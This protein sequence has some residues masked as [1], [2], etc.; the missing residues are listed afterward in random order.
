MFSRIDKKGKLR[1]TL[2]R[3]SLVGTHPSESDAEAALRSLLRPVSSDAESPGDAGG[4]STGGKAKIS[5]PLA[6]N[7]A[8][9]WRIASE[10]VGSRPSLESGD[11]SAADDIFAERASIGRTDNPVAATH[12]V[13][14]K[15]P[16]HPPATGEDSVFR[17]SWSPRKS[18]SGSTP[19]NSQMGSHRDAAL[20]SSGIAIKSKVVGGGQ[21]FDPSGVQ[22][23]PLN[24]S[25]E[26]AMG[27]G[28]ISNPWGLP[29]AVQSTPEAGDTFSP[30]GA[31]AEHAAPGGD[32][33]FS[34]PISSAPVSRDAEQSGRRFGTEPTMVAEPGDSDGGMLATAGAAYNGPECAETDLEG[35]GADPESNSA[36]AGQGSSG[37][38]ADA[39]HK[40]NG[41]DDTDHAPA[42][43]LQQEPKQEPEPEANEG[44]EPADAE[45]PAAE[46]PA[47]QKWLSAPVGA[48]LHT[49][50]VTFA[51][52][53]SPT[54]DEIESVVACVGVVQRVA[55]GLGGFWGGCWVDLFG[56]QA[57]GL[58][59]PG[60]DIDM[61]VQGV[62]E[63]MA[64]PQSQQE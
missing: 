51:R 57:M 26:L 27:V 19:R 35:S 59:V 42:S 17:I 36:D 25:S 6:S 14:A 16:S 44:G 18:A 5:A 9:G 58:G 55:R 53:L 4:S 15:P 7:P 2:W 8:E 10:D 29:S 56:S 28:G 50:I 33:Y 23:G 40:R 60:S 52:A 21:L 1:E 11:G 39:V 45:L 49:D 24:G 61:V 32:W 34:A 43:A 47:R 54:A 22:P 3:Y 30:P 62:V 48:R 41:A 12:G 46:A 20:E 37:G 38:D 31:P 13:A 64:P 63:R